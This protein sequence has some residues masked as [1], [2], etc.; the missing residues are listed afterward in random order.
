MLLA[1]PY[2]S[3]TELARFQRETEAVASVCHTNIVQ[4]FEVGYHEGRPY[5]TMELVEGGSLARKLTATPSPVQWAAELVASLADAVAVAHNAGFVHRDLKPANILL[6][7]D[8][9]PK[10]SDFGLARRL[11]GDEALTWTGTAVGTPSYM[12]PEQARGTPG[13]IGPAADVYGVGAILYEL[14]TGRPPFRGGTALETFRQVLGEEPVPPSRLDP[15]VPPDLEN[16]CLKCL[17]KDPH[18]RY[19]GAAAL[20]EDLQ[21]F[22]AGQ[23]VAARPVG[24]WE[25]VGKWIRRNPAVAS[26]SAAAAVAL[27]AGTVASLLFA[28]EARRQ[29]VI[30]TDRS[31]KL[32]KQAIELKA[33]T[34]AAEKNAQR[35]QEKEEEATRVFVSGLIVPLGRNRFPFSG[36]CDEAEWDVARNLRAAPETIRLQFLEAALHDP[37]A[38]RRVRCHAN[39][40]TYAIA[41]CDRAEVRRSGAA[42]RPADSGTGNAAGSA[43]GLCPIRVVAEH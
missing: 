15:Q 34:L 12:A 1:G 10:I 11:E 28:F 20:A 27:V 21:R 16:V 22:L 13:R 29:G 7:A 36:P 32:E 30:A 8:G 17:E 14:L 4:I 33:Q 23:V 25:R 41:G 9:I 3:P 31:G 42:D 24:H 18:R 37:D 43:A 19:P 40:M 26:L 2:A 5:F 35:A 38:A 6:T 39:W